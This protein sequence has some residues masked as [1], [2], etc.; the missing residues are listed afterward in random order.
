MTVGLGLSGRD[1]EVVCRL[2]HFDLQLKL[3]FRVWV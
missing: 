3:E 2:E 1:F